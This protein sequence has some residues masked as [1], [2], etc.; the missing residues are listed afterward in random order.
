MKKIFKLPGDQIIAHYK[1]FLP[2][3][4]YLM[5]ST[6][7]AKLYSVSMETPVIHLEDVYTTGILAARWGTL[8]CGLCGYL[9]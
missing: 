2:G 7:A 9:C 4:A 1:Q 8:C 6:T 3:P 5:S